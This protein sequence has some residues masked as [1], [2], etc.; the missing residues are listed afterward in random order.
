MV[1]WTRD[2]AVYLLVLARPELGERRLG[3]GLGRNRTALFLEPLESA[4]MRHLVESLVPALPGDA[5]GSLTARAEGIPLFAIETIRSLLDSGA[6]AKAG[7]GY[8][9]VGELSD[10]SVPES[11]HG[12]LASRLDAFEPVTRRLVGI[13]AVLG[14]TFSE[15]ALVALCGLPRTKSMTV[16]PTWYAG[17]SW[18]PIPSRC[19]PSVSATVSP[20]NSSAR[21]PTRR[22]PGGSAR[23][24]T[25]P[26]RPTCGRRSPTAARRSPRSSPAITWTHS[27]PGRAT[28][29]PRRSGSRPWPCWSGRPSAP[30]VPGHPGGRR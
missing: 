24:A 21:S 30:S 9:L 13:A 25:W 15:A 16:W 17:T 26:S 29:I 18:R 11:L 28:Q 6:V 12:L 1:D 2:L 14:T 5:L 20:T 8:R 22:C 27:P 10:L 4:A 3:L 23:I 19:R 7:E